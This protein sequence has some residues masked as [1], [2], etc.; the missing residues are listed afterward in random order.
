MSWQ[1]CHES[2][3]ILQ[4]IWA[5][6]FSIIHTKEIRYLWD[7]S[8]PPPHCPL[9]CALSAASSD[10]SGNV[11]PRLT[12][13]AAPAPAHSRSDWKLPVILLSGT[14]SRP[15]GADIP[16]QPWIFWRSMLSFFKQNNTTP[17]HPPTHTPLRTSSGFLQSITTFSGS[18]YCYHSSHCQWPEGRKTKKRHVSNLLVIKWLTWDSQVFHS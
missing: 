10:A 14:S 5:Q 17:P 11:F 1:L 9:S 3:D 15:L 13:S 18:N 8:F 4:Y 12:A 2:K 16:H 6:P 7:V